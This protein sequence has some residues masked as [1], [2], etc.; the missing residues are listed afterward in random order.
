MWPPDLLQGSRERAHASP[1]AQDPEEPLL[2]PLPPSVGAAPRT[3]LSQEPGTRFC[4][5]EGRM[6]SHSCLGQIVPALRWRC[7]P[8]DADT[9]PSSGS[10]QWLRASLLAEGS[11]RAAPACP[12]FRQGAPSPAQPSPA[13]QEWESR[14]PPP[15]VLP[16]SCSRLA[17]SPGA[18]AKLRIS[19]GPGAHSCAH[20]CAR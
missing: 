17:A 10:P 11:W 6:D 15:A 9:G 3:W 16:P 2:T 19:S 18:C 20:T 14:P 13:P 8:G 12:L 7:P 4:P 1:Q 5:G